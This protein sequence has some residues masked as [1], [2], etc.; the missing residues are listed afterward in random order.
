[1]RALTALVV[2][3][4][5][6]H[7]LVGVAL[8]AF[9][10][11]AYG[12]VLLGALA[13][14]TVTVLEAHAA[15]AR[16]LLPLIAV[17]LGHRLIATEYFGRTHLFL[18]GL[19]IPRALFVSVKAV[20]F[21]LLLVTPAFGSLL[22][23]FG[24]ASLRE[25]VD[26][27]YFGVV[28]ART[29]LWAFFLFAFFFATALAG[30]WR[31]PIYLLLAL[32]AW[33]LDSIAHVGAADHGP[34]A[35]VGHTFVLERRALPVEPLVT[36]LVASVALC[37]LGAALALGRGGSLA[38]SLAG[39]LSARERSAVGGLVIAAMISISA[40]DQ[41]PERFDP[42]VAGPGWLTSETPRLR[43]YFGAAER[44]PTARRVFAVVAADLSALAPIVG[45]EVIPPVF[46]VLREGLGREEV[47]REDESAVPVVRASPA[48]AAGAGLRAAVVRQVILSRT[49]GRADF[50]PAAW[51]LPAFSG[52]FAAQGAGTVDPA[53]VRRALYATRGRR[54]DREL[55]RRWHRTRERLGEPIADALAETGLHALEARHGRAAVLSLAHAFFDRPA[56]STSLTL[57]D[58]LLAPP[59]RLFE[60]A[61]GVPF[62][63]FLAEWR[64]WLTE[65]RRSVGDGGTRAS[66]A[67]ECLQAEGA[68]R[69][70]H[71]RVTGH[72]GSVRLRHVRLGPFDEALEER[73]LST[74][75]G[76]LVGVFA[77]GE[78]VF[79][80]V[81]VD[82]PVLGCPVRLL[83]LRFEVR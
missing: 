51:L 26:A 59:E 17:F 75:N 65:G 21:A 2:K 7:A 66:A 79:A 67:L 33:A 22:L 82:D 30:R 5:R 38:G 40:V 46:V 70:L 47:E 45:A 25:S 78:R 50:E 68:I 53:L 15:F 4:L 9:V 69:T 49:E 36:T 44:E 77:P 27:G 52:W 19:P 83:A 13:N 8:L 54:V 23:M 73:S 31:T 42:I 56:R 14:D 60:R 64:A 35:L 12:I 74:A 71:A 20:L 39:R 24:I 37:A 80:A 32:T 72:D 6:Q 1:V 48:T 16:Y 76:D 81:E 29:T 28:L 43:L 3:E 62:P 10:A 57:I 55:V 34:L 11:L 63:A 41:E 61:T 58:D 18:E